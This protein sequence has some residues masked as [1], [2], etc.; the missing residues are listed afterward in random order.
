MNARLSCRNV[1]VEYPTPHGKLRAVRGASFDVAPGETVALVGESGSGKSSVGRAIVRLLRPVSG[2]IILDGTDIAQFSERQLRQFRLSMQM[3]F[4]DPYGSLN[5]RQ[6]VRNLVATPL[7]VNRIGTS[8]ERLKRA[9]ELLARVGIDPAAGDRLPHEFSGG[10]RQRI[11]IARALALNPGLIVCD[12]AVSALDVSVQAQV[13][14]LLVD[15][16]RERGMSYLFI[17]HDL[18]AVRQIAHEIVVMYL[19]Q[20][21]A[22][23]PHRTFWSQPLHPYARRLLAATPTMGRFRDD[24]PP[25]TAA[26][27]DEI[28]SASHPP[29]GCSYRTR[30]EFAVDACAVV[31]P[32]LRE[33]RPGDFTACHRVSLD[34]LGRIT[35]PW[36]AA[37]LPTMQ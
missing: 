7:D 27:G 35:V 16:Q 12:E 25:E 3:I 29:S 18:A 11:A 15:L 24:P 17:S 33:M 13:L 2:S 5:P 21:M 32:V 28:P 36:E 6:R 31:P 1:V 8:A 4:Q 22:R 34:A 20:V 10:Q 9:D 26:A 37:P 23:A 30:C 14:N 19:G